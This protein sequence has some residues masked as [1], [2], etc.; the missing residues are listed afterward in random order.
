M[1]FRS[2]CSASFKK[3]TRWPTKFEHE[4][5][6]RRAFYEDSAIAIMAAMLGRPTRREKMFLRPQLR[7]LHGDNF[8]SASFKKATRWPT[9]FEHEQ[10]SRRAFYEDSAIAIMAAMH[11]PRIKV[12]QNIFKPTAASFA[13]RQLL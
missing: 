10:I 9:K 11:W 12:F 7:Q 6:S 5:I 2:F 3:A 1:L 13:R 4:Q 8:C